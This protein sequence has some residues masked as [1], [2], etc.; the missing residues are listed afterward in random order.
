MLAAGRGL[1][2][3]VGLLGAVAL[4]AG[5]G[6]S[7]PAADPAGPA[8]GPT[9]D[10]DPVITAGD[11]T[12]SV[13]SDTV[14]AGATRF[15]VRNSGGRSVEVSV[16]PVGGAAARAAGTVMVPPGGT[17]TLMPELAGGDYLVVCRPGGQGDGT[18]TP[19]SADGEDAGPAG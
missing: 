9:G 15:A 11:R 2:P 12:C 7:A 4:T 18:S 16:R 14:T 10:A 5:C 1:L 19:L 3:A 17:A 8:P 13:S 6:A